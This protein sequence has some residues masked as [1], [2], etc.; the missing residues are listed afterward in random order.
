MQENNM[1]T[2]TNRVNILTRKVAILRHTN[3]KYKLGAETCYIK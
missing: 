3:T 2:N 1:L